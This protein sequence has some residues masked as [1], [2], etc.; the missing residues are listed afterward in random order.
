MAWRLGSDSDRD[1]ESVRVV[2]GRPVNSIVGYRKSR[3]PD[4]R[5]IFIFAIS[6]RGHSISVFVERVPFHIIIEVIAHPGRSTRQ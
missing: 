1:F 2:V 6:S 5:C 3:V 4:E